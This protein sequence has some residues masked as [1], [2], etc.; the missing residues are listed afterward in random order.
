LAAATVSVVHGSSTPAMKL[1][2]S[3]LL[4]IDNANR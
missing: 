2:I 1:A 3:C 4:R